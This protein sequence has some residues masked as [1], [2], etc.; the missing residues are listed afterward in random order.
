VNTHSIGIFDSG[1]G[2]L[3]VFRELITLLPYRKVIYLGDT[4]R[5]PY[6]TK[7]PETVTRFSYQ[8]IRFLQTKGVRLIVVACNTVSALS[9]D[10]LRKKTTLPLMGVL[11]PG[12]EKAVKLTTRGIIGVIGTE[13]TI[14]SKAY[15]RIIKNIDSRVKVV[16][17]S[18]PLLV[19]LIE[20]GWLKGEVI[21]KYLDSWLHSL[22]PGKK[23]NS[24]DSGRRG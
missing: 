15:P 19:P 13:A 5:V 9:L 24:G 7:S 18:C 12:A 21:R 10:S 20:E 3:T 14:I 23:G 11:E 2:G 16:E 1:V 8:G 4:A 17:K 22:S 6:G